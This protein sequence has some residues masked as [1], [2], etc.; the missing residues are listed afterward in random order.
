MSVVTDVVYTV[1]V[2]DYLRDKFGKETG[3]KI[4]SFSTVCIESA[5]REF[6][7]LCEKYEN[8]KG[9]VELVRHQF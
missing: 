1:E 7:R 4:E 9:V 6:S 5:E 2:Y 8:D 3:Q